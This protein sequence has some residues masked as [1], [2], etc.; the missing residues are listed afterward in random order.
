MQKFEIV[1]KWIL[2]RM[3]GGGVMKI[4]KRRWNSNV[5]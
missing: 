2:E 3:M 5:W 1:A 4:L